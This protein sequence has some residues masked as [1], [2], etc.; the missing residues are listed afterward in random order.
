MYFATYKAKG[1]LGAHIF[2]PVRMGYKSLATL[3]SVD[4]FY[5]HTRGEHVLQKYG[6][7][8]GLIIKHIPC[9]SRHI[10]PLA[11]HTTNWIVLQI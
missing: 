9:Q 6:M 5:K 2:H 1:G 4:S 8:Q 7:F 3:D 11:T 10:S